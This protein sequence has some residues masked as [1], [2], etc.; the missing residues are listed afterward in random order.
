MR[1]PSQPTFL[2]PPFHI[3]STRAALGADA[4]GAPVSPASSRRPD[5]RAASLHLPQA[6]TRVRGRSAH[7]FFRGTPSPILRST[8]SASTWPTSKPRTRPTGP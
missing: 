5:G 8:P 4:T 3:V 6:P 2:S 1:S 7:A